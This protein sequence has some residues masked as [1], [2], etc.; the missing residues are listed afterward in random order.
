M[1][2]ASSASAAAAGWFEYLT[3]T[4]TPALKQHEDGKETTDQIIADMRSPVNVD[5]TLPRLIR[6]LDGACCSLMEERGD[7]EGLKTLRQRGRAETLLVLGAIMS[8][9]G[10]V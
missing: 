10:E 9:A 3:P 7:G 2:P 4:E 8:L 1:D 6:A 5:P